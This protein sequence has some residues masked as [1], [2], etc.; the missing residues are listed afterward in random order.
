[1]SSAVN[2]SG[3]K[4]LQ[5]FSVSK[6]VVRKT[7]RSQAKCT[8]SV[9]SAVYSAVYSFI[10]YRVSVTLCVCRAGLSHISWLTPLIVLPV[11]V[12]HS[13]ALILP[14]YVYTVNAAA[15]TLLSEPASRSPCS[16]GRLSALERWMLEP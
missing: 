11:V 15:L 2:H 16:R 13:A 8:G 14:Q 1:M 7:V 4:R 9:Y 10:V 5:L 6:Q 3:I 12:H